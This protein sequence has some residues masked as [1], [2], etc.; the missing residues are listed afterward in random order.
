MDIGIDVKTPEKTCED[1]NCPFHGTL[2]VRGQILEGM[3]VSNKMRQTVM[4]KREFMRHLKKYERYEKRRSTIAAHSPTCLN[5][6]EGDSVKIMECR[7]VSKA[8]TFV[9]IE[10]IEVQ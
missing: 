7:P 5:V 2:K 10:K 6:Q 8:K 1:P 4:V 9:V 3:V